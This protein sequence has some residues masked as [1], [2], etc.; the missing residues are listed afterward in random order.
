M[1]HWILFIALIFGSLACSKE[2]KLT[3]EELREQ[4]ITK[5]V[6]QFIENR[7]EECYQN[8]M[9]SAISM[10]DS[11][12]KINAVKYVE[13]SLQRPPLPVKPEKNIKPTPKDTVDNKP[14]LE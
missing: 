10:A 8:T 1:K 13:D 9:E 4:E 5:R 3:L 2:K 14:F 6:N 11:L 7:Q 12:L